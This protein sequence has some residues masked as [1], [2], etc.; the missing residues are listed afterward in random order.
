MQPSNVT[1]ISPQ[2]VQLQPLATDPNHFFEP[3]KTNP[4]WSKC[5]NML[6]KWSTPSLGFFFMS[7]GPLFLTLEAPMY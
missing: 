7:F 6:V 2:S 4:D 3:V 1:S 5:V